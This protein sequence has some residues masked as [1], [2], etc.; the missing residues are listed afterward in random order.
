MLSTDT[1]AQQQQLSASF[2]PP[3]SVFMNACSAKTIYKHLLQYYTKKILIHTFDVLSTFINDIRYLISTSLHLS[4]AHCTPTP[5]CTLLHTALVRPT[6]C[7][8]DNTIFI[9]PPAR[10]ENEFVVWRAHSPHSRHLISSGLHRQTSKKP[11]RIAPRRVL[12]GR[13]GGGGHDK[14]LVITDP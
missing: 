4:S 8:A 5:Y 2:E 6:P 1:N 12:R 10:V 14:R 3:T 13:W 11:H 9:T 7:M